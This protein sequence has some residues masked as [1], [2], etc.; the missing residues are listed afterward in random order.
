MAAS[1]YEQTRGRLEA[2]FDR[3][4][5]DAWAKLTS[6][7]PV[8]GI[9]ATVRA[10]RERMRAQLLGWLPE[11]M[12]GMTLLDAGCGTGALSLAAAQRGAAVTA[13]DL[14]PTLTDLGRERIAGEAGPGAID[15]KVGDMLD[16]AFGRFDF[17]VAMDSLIHY[18]QGDIAEALEQ[19]TARTE[20]A[21]IF[22]FAPRTPALS[23]MHAVGKLFPRSDRSPAIAP[24]GPKALRRRLEALEGWRF[25][26]TH[27]VQSGFYTS[28]A[29]RLVRL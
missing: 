9:R 16:P 18:R 25:D 2:Y 27:R 12:R 15:F 19:L 20:R 7:A 29:G 3:T 14:S 23:L 21:V 8:S 28:E 5:A 10:G 11:D 6:D 17:V 22:T 1:T 13:V 24:V 26:E 4:A